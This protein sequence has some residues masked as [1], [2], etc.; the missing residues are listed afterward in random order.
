[1]ADALNAFLRG[2]LEGGSRVGSAFK[3]YAAGASK[4]N[5]DA[6]KAAQE[7]LMAQLDQAA[8]AAVAK[9]GGLPLDP[10]AQQDLLAG[11]PGIQGSDLS[12]LFTQGLFAKPETPEAPPQMTPYQAWQ[13]HQ[14]MGGGKPKDKSKDKKPEGPPSQW[15]D[16][17]LLDWQQK[18][19]PR[20]DVVSQYDNRTKKTTSRK[21]RTYDPGTEELYQL[22]VQ[23]LNRRQGIVNSFESKPGPYANDPFRVTPPPAA[24][25]QP[26]VRVFNPATGKFE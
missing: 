7:Q 21:E 3:G 8:R 6:A 17:D 25:A 1:M 26:K 2:A 4:R 24:T 14:A 18:L 10:T 19:N 11:F 23:E 13:V 20:V 22:I 16:E 5:A 9:N 15:S 12:Y